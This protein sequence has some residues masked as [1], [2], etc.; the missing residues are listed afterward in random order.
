[1]FFLTFL[2]ANIQFIK[3][4]LIWR[5][6]ITVEDTP[7]TKKVKLINKRKFAKMAWN[8]NFVIFMVHIVTLK[9]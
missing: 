4:E 9:A 2:N 7:I 1:M 6:Y 5:I 8:K 3:K